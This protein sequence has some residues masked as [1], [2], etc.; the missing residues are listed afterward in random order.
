ML[1]PEQQDELLLSLFGTAEAMGQQLTPAA[2]QLMVQDLAAYEEPVLTAALQAVRREGGRFTV[3]AVLRHVESAD[4]RPE[5]NEAWAIALQS[6]DE[7]ETVLMTPEIQQA[8][9]VAAPL[10]KGRGDR[11]GARMAFIAAYERL[12]T[13]ARQQA[14]PARWSLSLGSDAG[15][16]AAAIEE[17]ERLGRL[18]APAAQ[19]LLEQHV[20]E[21]VTPAGSA[22]AGLLTGPSDRLLALTNDPLTRKAL[23]RE[24]AGGGDVPDDFRRRLEGI[25]KRLVRREKAKARLR[26]RHLRHEREDM[27][28]RRAAVL[29]TID[30]LQSQEVQHG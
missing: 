1:T 10:M 26:D 11:V 20:L 23:A 13:R 19:L 21:P 15:R 22:I 14:V 4:G 16:R 30:Q 25:K 2:A 7:A 3:A 28:R 17:A 27:D 12:L 18:P 8:A 29:Q 9:V 5:P 24:A 6:F